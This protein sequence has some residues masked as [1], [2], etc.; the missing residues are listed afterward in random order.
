[1]GDTSRVDRELDT[2][3]TKNQKSVLGKGQK[4]C[5]DLK[6]RTVMSI[7]GYV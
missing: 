1:M 7:A 2:R 4:Y 6:S 5:L 3:V